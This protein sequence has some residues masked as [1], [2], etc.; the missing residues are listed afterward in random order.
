MDNVLIE[1]NAFRALFRVYNGVRLGLTAQTLG[2]AEGAYNKSLQY[3]R[4][5]RQF[6]REICEFQGIQ[7]MIADMKIKLE[8]AKYLMYRAC[9][10]ADDGIPEREGASISKV[11]VAEITREVTDMAIQIFAGYGYQKD[12]PLEWYY[13]IVRGSSIAGGTL[14]I[15]KTAI[16]E[17]ALGRRFDQRPP[18]K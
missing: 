11:F 13:R 2:V 15:H 4:E 17:E 9:A 5:R 16:A 8:A 12:F 3:V 14:H 1:E 6:G 7:L 18:R 10:N